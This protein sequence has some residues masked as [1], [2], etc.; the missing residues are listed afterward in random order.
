MK[1]SELIEAINDGT[2]VKDGKDNMDVIIMVQT[3][4]DNKANVVGV[5]NGDDDRLAVMVADRM[6]K[7][8]DFAKMIFKAAICYQKYI[9]KKMKES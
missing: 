7:N 6:L 2:F 4:E 9:L 5:I 8:E 3:V 1:I